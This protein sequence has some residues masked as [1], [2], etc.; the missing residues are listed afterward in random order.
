FE[1]LNR[2]ERGGTLAGVA[3]ALDQRLAA[4]ARRVVLDNTYLTRA[5]RRDVIRAAARH[6]LPVR[7]VWLDTPLGEAQRNVVERM[8]VAHGALVPPE[9][10]ARSGDDPTRLAPRVLFAQA[11]KIERPEKDEGF[12]AV[13]VVPFARRPIA[14]HDGSG[15]A[16]ALEALVAR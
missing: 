12:A 13:E 4:G 3:A 10:L 9:E 1:R 2:D 16:V 7:C 11:Q 5:S 6:G 8:L 14:G 15:R